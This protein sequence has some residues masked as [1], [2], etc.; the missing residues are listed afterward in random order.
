MALTQLHDRKLVWDFRTFIENGVRRTH[1]E[2]LLLMA[3]N[4]VTF[5][6][7]EPKVDHFCNMVLECCEAWANIAPHLLIT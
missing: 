4:E 5:L 7:N 1:E 3:V 2:I 6:N